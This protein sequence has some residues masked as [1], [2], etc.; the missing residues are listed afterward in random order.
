MQRFSALDLD[1][2]ERPKRVAEPEPQGPVT[3]AQALAQREGGGEYIFAHK[4]G[5]T[6]ICYRV[7]QLPPLLVVA[8]VVAAVAAV[9]AVAVA[10]VVAVVAVVAAVVLALRTP[11]PA[12]ALLATPSAPPSKFF[13]AL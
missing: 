4:H 13:C 3:P 10:A 11:T 5:V 2:V 12:T 6:L 1:D 7:S 8:A 9:E